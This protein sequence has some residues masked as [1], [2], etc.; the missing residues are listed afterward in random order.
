MEYIS[1]RGGDIDFERFKYNV[2]QNIPNLPKEWWDKIEVHLHGG[3]YRGQVEFGIVDDE[4]EEDISKIV[5]LTAVIGYA[6]LSA[7]WEEGAKLAHY[8]DDIHNRHL[9]LNFRLPLDYGLFN[10][11]KFINFINILLK[12]AEQ[13]ELYRSAL[14]IQME[15]NLLKR[16][17]SNYRERWDKLKDSQGMI[18]K[19]KWVPKK[20]VAGSQAAMQIPGFNVKLYD[21]PLATLTAIVLPGYGNIV[22]SVESLS[23]R[24]LF[25]HLVFLLKEF[26][27]K[28]YQLD[29][30]TLD[31][32]VMDYRIALKVVESEINEEFANKYINEL[33]RPGVQLL[34]PNGLEKVTE[35][36]ENVLVDQNKPRSQNL[37]IFHTWGGRVATSIEAVETAVKESLLDMTKEYQLPSSYEAFHTPILIAHLILYEKQ[38]ESKKKIYRKVASQFRNFRGLSKEVIAEEYQ[39]IVTSISELWAIM[40]AWHN[41]YGR[42]YKKHIHESSLPRFEKGHV[43]FDQKMKSTEL[44]FWTQYLHLRF[45]TIEY[46]DDLDLSPDPT[47][48]K[49][50]FARVETLQKKLEPNFLNP[51]LI[52][53]PHLHADLDG[54]LGGEIGERLEHFKSNDELINDNETEYINQLKRVA[55]YESQLDKISREDY[56]NAQERPDYKEAMKSLGFH[57]QQVNWMKGFLIDMVN[58]PDIQNLILYYEAL[59][60]DDDVGPDQ[61]LFVREFKEKYKDDVSFL[62]DFEHVEYRMIGNA[63]SIYNEEMYDFTEKNMKEI[64][65]KEGNLDRILFINDDIKDSKGEIVPETEFADIWPERK[66]YLDNIFKEEDKDEP[67]LSDLM[68]VPVGDDPLQRKWISGM[69]DLVNPLNKFKDDFIKERRS[70]YATVTKQGMAAHQAAQKAQKDINFRKKSKAR[71]FDQLERRERSNLPPRGTGVLSN[72]RLWKRQGIGRDKYGDYFM[73]NQFRSA[74]RDRWGENYLEDGPQEFLDAVDLEGDHDTRLNAYKEA[75]QKID[76][77]E[78]F[79][80]SQVLTEFI[81]EI[82]DLERRGKA[83]EKVRLVVLDRYGNAMRDREDPSGKA[84]LGSNMWTLKPEYDKLQFNTIEEVANFNIP[85]K[86]GKTLGG[87]GRPSE[88]IYQIKPFLSIHHEPM[89][90]Q[91]G[92]IGA[93]GSDNL[94]PGS[95]DEERYWTHMDRG[96]VIQEE[97]GL[98][99]T[100]PVHPPAPPRA[101][102]PG[103]PV[104]QAVPP[105]APFLPVPR[106]QL[107]TPFPFTPIPRTMRQTQPSPDPDGTMMGYLTPR[108]SITNLLDG[109]KGV[110]KKKKTKRKNI[111]YSKRKNIRSNKKRY[112]RRKKTP[113]NKRSYSRKKLKSKKKHNKQKTRKKH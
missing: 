37:D 94:S 5:T 91:S 34:T 110:T 32:Q 11:R 47:T 14:D 24:K 66:R 39:E 81:E 27:T 88:D 1:Q 95:G 40:Y 78:P 19:G 42:I 58:A 55:I 6:Y 98:P 82:Q 18:V 26:V 68:K 101:A 10:R 100:R 92:D 83:D 106:A 108:R 7:D 15:G 69:T 62:Y 89:L 30:E 49:K 28:A 50:V 112:S 45:R 22:D 51:P 21:D 103:T 104:P 60:E 23:T 64:L 16:Q 109:G 57:K 74:A 80:D 12:H 71:L 90:L 2:N 25:I 77:E 59:I 38:E 86:I 41:L 33:V 44:G 105:T 73:P 67:D 99:G 72:R 70:K 61:L 31:Y 79:D 54:D 36:F 75:F 13:T 93:A 29:S 85:V 20:G 87:P 52:V 65:K 8:I 97:G 63:N 76:L 43:R 107:P 53:L 84:Y 4:G 113:L 56:F 3:I 111:S 48:F 102:L 35:V 96:Q 9:P 46:K 17:S